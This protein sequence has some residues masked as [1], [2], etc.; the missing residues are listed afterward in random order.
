MQGSPVQSPADFI[1]EFSHVVTSS[2]HPTTNA[3]QYSVPG[4]GEMS[5]DDGGSINNDP[6]IG[7][8]TNDAEVF[9]QA[10]VLVRPLPPEII[11]GQ[12]FHLEVACI[13]ETD[14]LVP[15]ATRDLRLK[16]PGA[17]PNEG[18]VAFV[19]YGGGFLSHSA[20]DSGAGGTI[21]V[22]YCPYDFDADGNAQK[23]HSITLDPTSGNESIII[24]HA[25]GL[26]V[27]MDDQD[28]HAIV[29]KNTD[30]SASLRVD[31]DGVT[32]TGAQIVLNG[33]VIVGS[34]LTAV[35]LLAG[36]ASPPSSKLFVSP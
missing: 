8:G 24:A 9:G 30:G 4:I 13:R 18:T 15:I 3:L 21:S 29:L 31:D 25:N 2:L 14:G 23:A 35:P 10:A 20:V 1:I 6:D 26:A 27:T 7:E 28:K 34:N 22:M 17:A 32:L 33:T 36:P 5:Q 11:D 19:G 16:M 12:V